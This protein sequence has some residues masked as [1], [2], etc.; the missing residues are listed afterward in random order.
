MARRDDNREKR[1]AEVERLFF[2]G[3]TEADIARTLRLTP[4]QVSG[5]I[6]LIRNTR[7]ANLKRSDEE[8]RA[9]LIGELDYVARDLQDG[10]E[11]TLEQ[12]EIRESSR[13]TGNSVTERV[14]FRREPPEPDPR[15]LEEKRHCL[16][17][18]AGLLGLDKGP[19]GERPPEPQL[20][21]TAVD[22]EDEYERLR[23]ILEG[24]KDDELPPTA[25][26]LPRGFP[27][28][29]SLGGGHPGD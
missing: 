11:L 20:E 10:Y 12:R 14:G 17:L 8:K 27:P 3:E 5:C 9:D 7:I 16:E 23:E 1:L 6:R 4:R 18:K 22:H 15:F 29:P 26:E 28:P 2:H 24:G 19:G 25:N 21:I 13:I